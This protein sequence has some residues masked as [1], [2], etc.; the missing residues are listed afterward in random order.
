MSTTTSTRTMK[1]T[2]IPS[3]RKAASTSRSS[4]R[5]ALSLGGGTAAATSTSTRSSKRIRK[6]NSCNKKDTNIVKRFAAELKKVDPD[7]GP[8][9][10]ETIMNLIRNNKNDVQEAVKVYVASVK[11]LQYTGVKAQQHN[12]G[13][14]NPQGNFLLEKAME[15]D[16]NLDMD[17]TVIG[18]RCICTDGQYAEI[19]PMQQ[20]IKPKSPSSTASIRTHVSG[21]NLTQFTSY[22]GLVGTGAVEFSYLSERKGG[23]DPDDILIVVVALD[24][25]E[26]NNN[27]ELVNIDLSGSNSASEIHREEAQLHTLY[28]RGHY[29]YITKEILHRGSL[30]AKHV[31]CVV[32]WSK[33]KKAWMVDGELRCLGLGCTN[34]PVDRYVCRGCDKFGVID[35]ARYSKCLVNGCVKYSIAGSDFCVT[36]GGKVPKCSVVGC[37]SQARWCYAKRCSENCQRHGAKPKL[38]KFKDCTNNAIKGG[39]CIRHGAKRKNCK[40]DDC[41]N[42]VKKG[43]VCRKHG[44]KETKC[45]FKDCT[46]NARKGGICRKHGAKA[47]KCKF[48]DCNN[49]ARKGGVCYKHGSD[50]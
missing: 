49:N 13:L 8:P 27:G 50:V 25:R 38:C 37:T 34:M 22:S 41:N 14:S 36:H 39:V 46:N 12:S 20:G 26:K 18:F 24:L 16:P 2:R 7:I 32:P 35:R 47:T 4:K 10:E 48:D 33:I 28:T 11:A 23:K 17:S 1:S 40:F 21:K 45:K 3:R 19:N 5:T 30:S 44:A 31:L 15:M 9:N 6:V 29:S 43:G 42:K